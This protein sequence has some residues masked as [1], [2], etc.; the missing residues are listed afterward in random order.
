VA[1]P[2]HMT[3]VEDCF[4]HEAI[5]HGREKS[6]TRAP[7]PSISQIPG[8][9]AEVPESAC[10][11]TTPGGRRL[12]LFEHDSPYVRMSKMGGRTNLLSHPDPPSIKREPVPYSKPD[13]M[14]YESFTPPDTRTRAPVLPDYMVYDRAPPPRRQPEGKPPWAEDGQNVFQ[15][16]GENKVRSFKTDKIDNDIK[17]GL[18]RLNFNNNNN[19]NLQ[20]LSS[21]P[22]WAPKRS[23]AQIRVGEL[24]ADFRSEKISRDA[25]AKAAATAAASKSAAAEVAGDSNVGKSTG[26]TSGLM[27][28]Y[29]PSTSPRK[30]SQ[31]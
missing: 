5:T 1:T 30:R 18:K 31:D 26:G 9:G 8:W 29:S 19:N 23:T 11:A 28:D 25:K 13:W 2:K 20:D 6:T 15:R 10:Y 4:Y 3:G 7:V 12:G 21:S 16:E 14:V 27:G 17:A 22:L 24:E